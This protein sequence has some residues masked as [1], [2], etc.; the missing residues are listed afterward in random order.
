[1]HHKNEHQYHYVLNTLRSLKYTTNVF[2]PFTIIFEIRFSVLKNEQL[3][4]YN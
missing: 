3:W 4:L 1:M 2:L